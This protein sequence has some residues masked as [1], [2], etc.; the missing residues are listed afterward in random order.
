MPLPLVRVALASSSL[1]VGRGFQQEL[2]QAQGPI[3]ILTE[4][5]TESSTK[6][7]LFFLNKLADP[8]GVELLKL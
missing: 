5:N 1:T 3:I 4:W 6:N 2:R 8:L 7:L